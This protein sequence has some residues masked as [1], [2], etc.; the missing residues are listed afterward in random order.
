MDRRAVLAG[1]AAT[2]LAGLNTP[3]ARAKA[4]QHVVVIGAGAAGMTAAYLLKRAG[5]TVTV[6]EAADRIGGR[7]KRLNGFADFPID[8]GAEWIHTP[9]AVLDEI[10]DNPAIAV[11]VETI[12]YRPKTYDTWDDGTLGSANWLRLAYAEHKFKHTTWFGFFERHLLPSVLSDIRLGQIVQAITWSQD[13]VQV[14]TD[15]GRFD[16]DQVV[17]TVPL[18][19]LQRGGIRFG[20]GLPNRVEQALAD[21]VFGA[22]LKVFMKF[23]E[24]FY[25][26]IVLPGGVDAFMADEWSSRL[27]YDAAFGKGRDTHVLGLFQ[28]SNVPLASRGLSD[29]QILRNTLAELDQIYDGLPSQVFEDARVQNWDRVPHIWGT[30]SNDYQPASGRTLRQA[31]API[32][33][34]LFFAGEAL[35]GEYRSTVHGAA[36]SAFE[37]VEDLLQR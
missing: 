29:A 1:A 18:S 37:A 27:F 25:A 6:L 22:G 4:G 34:R 14:T 2:L 17:V 36:F 16:A 23:S 3:M 8:L 7:M 11:D 20:P 5:A 24:R 12:R 13:G 10:V 15:Q 30:Y 9:P 32:D 35:G 33:G 31:L 28:N 19:V 26:D 21:T